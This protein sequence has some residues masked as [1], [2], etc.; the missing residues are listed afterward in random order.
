MR[1][2]TT[3]GSTL[4]AVM[5][6]LVLAI[7]AGNASA[8]AGDVSYWSGTDGTAKAEA[9]GNGPAF[10]NISINLTVWNTSNSTKI[11]WSGSTSSALYFANATPNGTHHALGTGDNGT[12]HIHAYDGFGNLTLNITSGVVISSL[13]VTF[14]E[15][16]NPLNNTTVGVGHY[17]DRLNFTASNLY[18]EESD[19]YTAVGTNKTMR[20]YAM[21]I[22]GG[23][24]DTTYSGNATV[25]IGTGSASG[26]AKLYNDTQYAK[27]VRVAISTGS[28]DVIFNG[29]S[30]GSTTVTA[31]SL[32]G[33][34]LD[35]A[36]P[37]TV[38]VS[39]GSID[40]FDV[41]TV[42]NPAITRAG[43]PLTSITVEARDAYGN[44]ITDFTEAVTFTSNS[45]A[46]PIWA[47]DPARDQI[48]LP[49]NDSFTTGD[50]GTK[51]FPLFNDTVNETVELTVTSG[52]ATGSAV[53]TV[54]SNV[55]YYV[56]IGLGASG[57]K[58]AGAEFNATATVYDWFYNVN[59][60]SA[61]N[62]N[63]SCNA[64]NATASVSTT[65]GTAHS[66]GWNNTTATVNGPKLVYVN[67]TNSTVEDIWNETSFNLTANCTG[68][69]AYPPGTS[70]PGTNDA[71]V[72]N[73]E[74]IP[75]NATKLYTWYNLSTFQAN[76]RARAASN[77]T[78]F[79][80]DAYD[81][82][83]TKTTNATGAQV[84]VDFELTGANATNASFSNVATDTPQGSMVQTISIPANNSTSMAISTVY[85]WSN[86]ALSETIDLTITVTNAQGLTNATPP[87]VLCNVTPWKVDH[88]NITFSHDPI[89]ANGTDT[90]AI[91]AY[92]EDDQNVT[93][94]TAAFN[95]T[96]DFNTTDASAIATGQ[97]S[98]SNTTTVQASSGVVTGVSVNA[99]K[100]NAD[101][102]VDDPTQK[103][104][105]TANVTDSTYGLA[106]STGGNWS[107][108]NVT[109]GPAAWIDVTADPT[110][111]TVGGTV[112]IN[113][114]VCD[115]NMNIV[116][117]GTTVS[118]R[119]TSGLINMSELTVMG[120]ASPNYT[121]PYV[122]STATITATADI[123]SNTTDVVFTADSP[124]CNPTP[125][126]CTY[127]LY[128]SDDSAPADGTSTVTVTVRLVDDYN[129]TNTITNAMVY[130]S[131]TRGTF[132]A[133]E[134]ELV[135]GV[136]QTTLTSPTSGSATVTANLGNW[137][138]DTEPMTFTEVAFDDNITLNNGWNLISVP[139]TL[140]GSTDAWTV[141]NLTVDDSVQYYDGSSWTTA[142]DQAIEPCK[143]YWI[144]NDG[145][146]KTVTLTYKTITGAAIPP[147]IDLPAGWSMI[148][149]TSTTPI[150]VNT[151]LASISS[152]Y[153]MVL[154]SPS[155]GVWETYIPSS[156]IQDF[157]KMQ[158]GQGY[159]IF[160]MESG[161]YAAI[162]T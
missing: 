95:V 18:F 7:A 85:L 71:S 60:T 12:H 61:S 63:V 79:L 154:T 138:Q 106:Y 96:F 40:H 153:S 67:L 73:I 51:V 99:T 32:N 123:G 16:G 86:K 93:V 68:L 127:M 144:R 148:G 39:A 103:L 115:A 91:I 151:A 8:A 4:T 17:L 150:A 110:T 155:P 2:K 114:T 116:L 156:S 52:S 87:N 23:A 89:V 3:T 6:L 107:L 44:L 84:N 78:I 46:S 69:L 58:T 157:T 30:K 59:Y 15:V 80:R 55:A 130:L 90:A 66:A 141:F 26:G 1:H 56:G 124:D 36:T 28:G 97:L 13:I 41:I 158:P 72:E 133:P 160:M 161:T 43:E 136:Y 119:T 101:A 54:G 88:I 76:G 162:S 83:C 125:P 94:T 142:L 57:N 19:Y 9:S 122:A 38:H 92:L 135:N 77:I 118:F 159:W 27:S 126:A 129:N 82:N 25:E 33:V 70:S 45:S 74:V 152:S 105:V 75:N 140:N 149:H 108:L 111:Q 31:I 49:T 121:S 24:H 147:S 50:S 102:G 139:K 20:I 22:Q 143:G 48:R 112:V 120:R 145:T 100:T 42:P 81:N 65:S 29:T 132:A 11:E 53:I 14:T 5:V 117:N 47:G 113:S 134:G 21:G 146:A 10:D 128:L 109:P 98:V 137:G 131:T 35:D 62:M 34:H 104:N 64:P 37:V